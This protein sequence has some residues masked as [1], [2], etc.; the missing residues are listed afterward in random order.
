MFRALCAAGG[1]AEAPVD[2]DVVVEALQQTLLELDAEILAAARCRAPN[3]QDGATICC[4]L[5]V[6]ARPR[7][8]IFVLVQSRDKAL[9]FLLS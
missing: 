8:C 4:G 7:S 1:V 2:V 9:C 3:E 6:S 5:Q